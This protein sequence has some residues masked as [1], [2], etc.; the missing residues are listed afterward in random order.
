MPAP[1]EAHGAITQRREQNS[2]HQATQI[3]RFPDGVE[4][5]TDPFQRHLE[6]AHVG[7]RAQQPGTNQVAEVKNRW[8]GDRVGQPDQGDRNREIDAKQHRRESGGKHLHRD[9]DHGPEQAGSDSPR[10]RI[11]VQMP[12]VCVMQPIAEV[13]KVFVFL[14]HGGV[15]RITFDQVSGH[16]RYFR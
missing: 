4:F 16:R 12:Q 14:Q 15:W 9:R 5:R 7:G 11:P 6:L 10:D 8:H 2:Q 1:I 3:Q 13:P